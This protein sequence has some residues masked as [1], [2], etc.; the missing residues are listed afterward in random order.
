[1]GEVEVIEPI[2]TGRY[3]RAYL[4]IH[5]RCPAVQRAMA[6]DGE[7]MR[8]RMDSAAWL[9]SEAVPPCGWCVRRWRATHDP[10]ANRLSPD[11]VTPAVRA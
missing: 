1:M 11:G 2:T 8:G 5:D 6:R 3:G 7:V 4:H 10:A 9:A